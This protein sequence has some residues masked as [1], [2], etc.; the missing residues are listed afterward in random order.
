MLLQELFEAEIP[1]T[2]YGYWITGEGEFIPVATEQH[3][4]VIKQHKPPGLGWATLTSL[5]T[6]WG[7]IRVVFYDP[8]ELSFDLMNP[9]EAALKSL[10]QLITEYRDEIMY[11]YFSVLK[12]PKKR[13]GVGT[14]DHYDFHGPRAAGQTLLF[15]RNYTTPRT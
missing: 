2:R 13:S 1:E 10:I 4:R 15:L 14:F 9:T 11:V 6:Q 5:A 8:V 12:D 7:W 3:E